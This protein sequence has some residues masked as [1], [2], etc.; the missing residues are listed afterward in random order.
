MLVFFKIGGGGEGS[1]S[2]DAYACPAEH[3]ALPFCKASEG[4]QKLTSLWLADVVIMHSPAVIICILALDVRVTREA[5]KR[6]LQNLT[7]TCLE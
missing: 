3:I 1:P 5:C 6:R 4:D 7:T 2:S